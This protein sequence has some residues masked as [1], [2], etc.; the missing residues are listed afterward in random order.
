MLVLVS[1]SSVGIEVPINLKRPLYPGSF[2]H[3]W[4]ILLGKALCVCRPLFCSLASGLK[5]WEGLSVF[6]RL[7]ENVL[8]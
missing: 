8:H 1:V 5:V 4:E 6:G 7:E 3:S 2:A